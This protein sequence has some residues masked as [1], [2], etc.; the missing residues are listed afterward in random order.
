MRVDRQMFEHLRGTHPWFGPEHVATLGP[1]E[2]ARYRELLARRLG[3]RRNADPIRFG[4]ALRSRLQH[5]EGLNAGID[6][7]RIREAILRAGIALP[8]SV[9]VWSEWGEMDRIRLEILEEVWDDW[10]VSGRDDYSVFDGGLA[11][12]IDVDVSGHVGYC[13]FCPTSP[14]HEL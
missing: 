12:I 3:V 8:S 7:F 4:H 14:G 1:E 5:L 13:T 2:V 10:Y 6:R 11:W 9:I